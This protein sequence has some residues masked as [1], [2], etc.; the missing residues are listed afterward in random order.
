ATDTAAATATA[1]DTAAATATA[2][3]TTAPTGT[4]TATPTQIPTAT[5]TLAATG[6][7]TETATPAGVTIVV[8]NVSGGIGPTGLTFHGPLQ[9]S[10]EVAGT[11][12][13]ITL[14]PEIQI[15]TGNGGQP[16]CTANPDIEK[17]GTSFLQTCDG[18]G[19]C[20][21]RAFVLA[22]DNVNPIPTGSTLYTCG[23]V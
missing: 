6:T 17:N 16:L 20:H 3:D 8:G 5:Q 12:N 19:V 11:Q 21:L 22:L 7:A 1:T 4:A 2:T 9:T 14:G 18:S 15:A 10:L 13:D 23:M